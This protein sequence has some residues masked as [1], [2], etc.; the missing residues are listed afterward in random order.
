MKYTI[1]DIAELCNVGKST[2][3]RVLNNDPNVKEQ[4]RKKIQA[5]IEQVGFQPSRNARAMRGISE[6]VVG[7][8]VTRLNSSSESQTLS[9]IL[10]ELEKHD[11]TPLIVESQ[12]RQDA[13]IRHLNIFKQRQVNGIIVFAFSALEEDCLLDWKDRMVTIV[14]QYPNISSVSYDDQNA[15]KNLVGHFYQQGYRNISYLGVDDSDETTGKLRNQAYRDACQKYEISCNITLGNLT[16][17]SAYHN[18]SELFSSEV[19]AI[20]C[21]SSSL[22]V[23]A[24]KFLQE[25]QKKVPLACIGRNEV[26]QYLFP[27]ILFLDF[28]YHEAGKASVELLLEQLDGK[29]Q[30]LPKRYKVLFK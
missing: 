26:L 28:G 18:V 16:A 21:A 9:A 22:A 17:E 4:T 8:I 20:V 27:D 7:V 11:I 2:V 6:R 30:S 12:F 13:V 15:I 3:S 24:F 5:V 23:G 10:K 29:E 1:K 19:D 25:N 14:K